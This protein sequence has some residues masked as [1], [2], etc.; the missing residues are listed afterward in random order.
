MSFNSLCLASKWLVLC[1]DPRFVQHTWIHISYS[2]IM[3]FHRVGFDCCYITRSGNI[4]RISLNQE[5]E[6]QLINNIGEHENFVPILKILEDEL[7]VNWNNV[8]YIVNFRSTQIIARMAICS[9]VSEIQTG[10]MTL[11]DRIIGEYI[12]IQGSNVIQGRS[13]ASVYLLDHKGRVLLR[14]CFDDDD[15]FVI[16]FDVVIRRISLYFSKLEFNR[17]I[18]FNISQTRYLQLLIGY[19]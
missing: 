11:N 18:W 9:N 13:V 19:N 4:Y 8:I 16:K 6:D 14:K 15:I 12:I 7:I 10:L 3:A 5:R 1:C 17:V 2:K